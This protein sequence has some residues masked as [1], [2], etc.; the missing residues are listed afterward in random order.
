MKNLHNLVVGQP[1][2]EGV[3][4]YPEAQYYQYD[5]NGHFVFLCFNNLSDQETQ[6]FRENKIELSFL[7]V[8]Q[9]IFLLLHIQGFI[10][11]SDLPYSYHL[12]Y[13]ELKKIPEADFSPGTGAPM[14]LVLVEG[15]TGIVKGIRILGLSSKFSNALHRE[16]QEQAKTPFD[17]NAYDQTIDEVRSKFSCE[18]LRRFSNYYYRG[19]DPES[20]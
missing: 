1:Y 16:I 20:D 4:N 3:T 2:Q 10:D 19:G 9:V 8:K 13:D 6:A 15:N 7:V 5:V 18:E 12:V 17:R 14:L 11:W